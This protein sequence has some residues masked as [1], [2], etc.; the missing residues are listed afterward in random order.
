MKAEG[1]RGRL[2]PAVA[3]LWTLLAGAAEDVETLKR[4]S[5]EEL[6]D[7]KVSII[8][9]RPE[10]LMESAA[11]VYVL[12]ADDIRRSGY[13]SIPELMR[14][15][16][17]MDVARIDAGEW[18]IS[19]RGFNSRFANKLLVMV[20][21]RSVYNSL[22]SGVYWEALDVLL[23]DVERIEV[24]R[25]PGAS[26]WGA[27]A[28]NGV[29]NIITRSADETQ[30]GLL[31]ARAGNRQG[32]GALRQGVPV[33]G[34]HL[35]FYAKYDDQRPQ[36]LLDGS[37]GGDSLQ[38]TLVG[39]RGDWQGDEDSTLMVQG[40]W[41]R[42]NG[43]DPSLDG[44]DLMFDWQRPGDE[45]AMD[46]IHA[47]YSRF[48]MDTAHDEGELEEVE[49]T[50]DLEYR[51]QFAPLGR[52]ELI[53]G[54]GYR[55]QRSSIHGGA[56]VA[57][58]PPVRD[59]N[60]L[61]AFFQDEI[62][63]FDERL[64]VTL[65][66]KLEH[67]DYTG[68]EVQPTVRARWQP[69]DDAVLWG[70]VS[71]AVRTPSRSE[72]DLIGEAR[73]LPPSPETGGLPVNFRT[74]GGRVMTS[75]ILIAYEAGYRWRPLPMLGLDLALF[76][77]DY[78]ELRTMEVGTPSLEFDPWIRWVVPVVARNDLEGTTWGLELVADLRPDEH[79]RL[80]AWYSYLEM[81]LTLKEGSTDLEGE[82]QEGRSPEHQ[83]GLRAG[84]D[85]ARDLELDLFLRY[86]SALPDLDVDAYTEL[87]LRLGWR[88]VQAFSLS[89]VG[90][91]LLHDGHQEF[92]VEPILQG[93]PHLIARELFLQLEY[94]F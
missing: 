29:I 27:N 9:K 42:A 46:T 2:L 84:V 91:N 17:G 73:G 52:H 68:F 40:S 21:G 78:Q 65:G 51:H 89:L 36:D 28:V 83:V 15:V 48:T 58:D 61:S 22:F 34:G 14:L 53:V 79:W 74:Q 35:R 43:H 25:G 37:P 87:D 33:G 86:V 41:Y 75:E 64:F 54:L 44:G 81:D 8:A 88:P 30:G 80:Q 19:S 50:I 7:L 85:L 5:L 90:R 92:G 55:W 13:T 70:A 6:A 16:P 31:Q 26:S 60:R 3:L 94:R 32:G 10:R 57:A 20:D 72:H 67:N 62:A 66:T 38:R 23:D 77:N 63:L 18:A 24:I 71:R 4:L 39:F 47:Y 11:A 49:D 45:G 12:T 59:L 56:F 82:R 69:R 93:E 76:Y 1:P